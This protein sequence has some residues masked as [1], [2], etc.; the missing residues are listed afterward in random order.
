MGLLIFYLL[1]AIGISFLC[2]VLEAV[3]LSVSPSFV[4]I[5][6]EEEK[7]S[8]KKSNTAS[9]KYICDNFHF[10]LTIPESKICRVVRRKEIVYELEEKIIRWDD[11][12]LFTVFSIKDLLIKCQVLIRVY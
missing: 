8:V 4:K 2:S 3:I 6:V 7:S 5:K 10:F 9:W 11:F 12:N 1:L